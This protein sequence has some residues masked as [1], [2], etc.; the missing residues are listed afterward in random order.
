MIRTVIFALPMA[1]AWMMLTGR[2]SLESFILGYLISG[3]LLV[4]IRRNQVESQLSSGL[5]LLRYLA[6]LTLDVI[7]ADLQVAWKILSPRDTVRSRIIEVPLGNDTDLSDEFVAA[8]SSH[9]IT[10]TPGSLV[11][12]SS[13]DHKTLLVHTMNAEDLPEEMTEEQHDRCDALGRI[14]DERTD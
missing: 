5:A 3:L 11:V 10:L 7:R 13:P 1:I 14:F 6:N 9:A 12:N 8:M 4:L 2:I